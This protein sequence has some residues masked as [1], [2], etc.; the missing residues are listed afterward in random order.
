MSDLQCAAT[1]YVIGPE[2]DAPQELPDE[3]RVAAV[4]SGPGRLADAEALARRWECVARVDAGLDA[5]TWPPPAHDPYEAIADLH[6]GESV[7][8]LPAHAYTGCDDSDLAQLRID[9]DGRAIRL[10]P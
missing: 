6:R 1:L 9:G 3:A 4:W 10:L 5:P 2:A 8:V 7:L